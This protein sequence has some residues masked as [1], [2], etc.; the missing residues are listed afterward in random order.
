MSVLNTLGRLHREGFIH[1]N[2]IASHVV[3]TSKNYRLISLRRVAKHF[4]LWKKE[5]PNWDA[6]EPKWETSTMP[7]H[8][9]A[10]EWL[11]I[12]AD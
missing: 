6:E 1:D 4:C 11:Q 5:N 8:R 9:L 3:G 12:V 2:P 7:C 10:S